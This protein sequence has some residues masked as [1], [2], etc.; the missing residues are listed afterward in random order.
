MY[1]AVS[2][3]CSLMIR[4][5]TTQPPALCSHGAAHF[6]AM[7]HFSILFAA[8]SKLYAKMAEG[9]S[10]QQQDSCSRLWKGRS[11]RS[12]MSISLFYLLSHLDP[13][14]HRP[15][16]AFCLQACSLLFWAHI[17]SLIFSICFASSV[18]FL[19]FAL[20]D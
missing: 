7:T 1:R 2:R 10:L 3:R 8:T 15:L 16:P 14:V 13:Y 9:C 20:V 19:D 17:T 6:D 12:C 5:S 18:F 4:C 11:G